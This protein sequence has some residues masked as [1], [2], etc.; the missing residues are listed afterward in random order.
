MKN[1]KNIKETDITLKNYIE[2]I[3][4]PL[5]I[6]NGENKP[7]TISFSNSMSNYI[8]NYFGNKKINDISSEDIELCLKY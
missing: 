6:D 3:V 8:F 7:S 4:L 5:E 1:S 2:E